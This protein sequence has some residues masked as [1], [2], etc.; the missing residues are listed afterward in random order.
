MAGYCFRYKNKMVCH[1]SGM[2]NPE[3]VFEVK[4][5]K[6]WDP[7]TGLFLK[8]IHFGYNTD[9]DRSKAITKLKDYIDKHYDELSDC[10]SRLGCVN[11]TVEE[12]K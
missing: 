12:I 9:K 10:P 11:C 6:D 7:N 5:K 2:G 8:G 4:R 3:Y 1:I